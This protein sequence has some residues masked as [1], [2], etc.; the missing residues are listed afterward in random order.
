MDERLA[1]R[2]ADDE[3]AAD[4]DRDAVNLGEVLGSSQ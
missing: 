2:E 3:T 4:R 1:A